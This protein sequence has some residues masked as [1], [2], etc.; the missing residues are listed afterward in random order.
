MA[1]INVPFWMVIVLGKV[2]KIKSPVPILPKA[3]RV[4]AYARVSSGK[5]EMLHSLSAQVSFYS[6]MIQSHKGWQYIGVYADE[7]Q[8]GTRDSRENFQRLLSD[9]RA[10]KINIVITKSISRFARNTVTLLSTIRE[11]KEMGIDVYF[12][13]QNIHTQSSDGE[14]LITLLAS[15]AQ[16]ESRSAS[17]NQ[18]WRVKKNFQEG[19]PWNQ[20]LYGYRFETDHFIVIPEE[21]T[22][23]RLICDM[24][25]S[26]MGV[27]AIMKRLNEEGYTTRNGN[28]WNI[29]SIRDILENYN[30]TGNLVLQKTFRKDHISK[31]TLV[32]NGEL[33]KYHV[34][35]SHEA[36][37]PLEL[38]TQIQKEH[39]RR[40][41]I[42]K[43]QKS[44]VVHTPF[45]GKVYCGLCGKTYKRKPTTTGYVW[46]CR[47]FNTYGK[48][49]CPSKQIPET[50]LI[51]LTEAVTDDYEKV[52]RIEIIPEN[53]VRFILTD[54]Q[55]AERKWQDRSRSE[56]WTPE[57]KEAARQKTMERIQ[58]QC[59]EQ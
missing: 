5:D 11:L 59:K 26:G 36:I 49:E 50:T 37:I 24:Y 33:P 58:K 30:Y 25:L 45:S 44:R 1:V 20:V 28:K 51:N 57:M 23:I 38:F 21:A 42:A 6:N 46:I 15:Y 54:E 14:L 10:G 53:T 40:S 27:I 18:K 56:S 47:T 13:E 31:K 16:E 9:C 29:G 34:E 43:R 52:Q 39:K 22:V 17:E 41:V 3:I 32:N 48:A 12:E 19:I 55:T 35:N 8:T 2:K 7:A 4:A